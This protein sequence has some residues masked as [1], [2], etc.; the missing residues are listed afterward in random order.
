MHDLRDEEFLGE[1]DEGPPQQY[2]WRLCRAIAL[3]AVGAAM[4][5]GLPESGSLPAPSVSPLPFAGGDLRNIGPFVRLD[6]S[7]VFAPFVELDR[8]VAPDAN[9]ERAVGMTGALAS[10]D[11]LASMAT[12]GN[13]SG[14]VLHFVPD[15]NA[16]PAVTTADPSIVLA[17][18]PPPPPP[19]P[20]AAA[21]ERAVPATDGSDP[22]D[23]EVPEAAAATL[24]A[25]KSPPPIVAHEDSE[26]PPARR[27]TEEELVRRLIDEYAGAFERLDVGAAKAVWPTVDGK[28][29]QRAF[30]QL[31]SQRL[32]LQSCGIT[33]S[34][35]TANARCRGSATYQPR[36]GT[37]P[38]EIASREWT[39]DL[40][41]QDADWRIVNTF[42][43]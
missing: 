13:G 6:R 15:P 42:V 36:I 7:I 23:G 3:L 28:A 27:T 24:R 8:N 12:S 31:A 9:A 26:E 35:S 37:R 29:L 33:I 10:G 34:G 32:T 19:P 22:G 1:Y 43:R 40:S 17:L 4:H 21:V 2:S 16:L 14:P 18:A 41:K 5:F 11:E 25:L 38:V 30:G 39:F 20:V